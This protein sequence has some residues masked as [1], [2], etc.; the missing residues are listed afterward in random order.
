MKVVKKILVIL[1]WMCLVGCIGFTVYYAYKEWEA[2]RCQSVV[3]TIS[4]GSPR[5]LDEDDITVLI[6]NSG[7]PV[8]GHFLAMINTNKLEK[9]L[10]TYTTLKN[11]EIFRR[12]DA[13]G[14]S[15][16]GKL[17]VNVDE[18]SPVVRM[19]N[20]NEDYYFDQSGVKIPVTSKYVDR[21]LIASGS[22]PDEK[23]QKNFFKMAE[24]V[25][26][27]D[28]WKAQIEQVFVQANGELLLLP[29]VGDYLIDFGT[30][31]DYEIKFRN[32]KSVY[33]QGFKNQGW[34]KYK[35]ISVKYRN[36]VVCTKK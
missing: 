2:V 36:Q 27:D 5:F 9:K 26:N 19:K 31:D 17:V 3:V 6:A 4:P 8:I 33:Q 11:V 16:K 35:T 32:L 24:F 15:F 25:N 29:Q 23:I 1:G 12:I 21:I 28:F 30:P 10:E 22:V 34:N 20:A 18:R 14:L 13:K 7:E